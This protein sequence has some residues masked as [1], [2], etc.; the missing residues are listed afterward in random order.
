[1]ASPKV[2]FR[3]VRELPSAYDLGPLMNALLRRKDRESRIAG[4]ALKHFYD[5]QSAFYDLLFAIEVLEFLKEYGGS[6]NPHNLPAAAQGACFAHAIL[7]YVRA[8]ETGGERKGLNIY[9]QLSEK[10]KELHN[11]LDTLRNK[12]IA[13]LDRDRSF[14][15]KSF[16]D[17]KLV[18]VRQG[19]MKHRPQVADRR[20]VFQTELESDVREL[21]WA[22]LEICEKILDEKTQDA[23]KYVS[24]LSKSDPQ[25]AQLIETHPFD[26][27][28]FFEDEEVTREFLEK[29][30]FG[31]STRRTPLVFEGWPDPPWIGSIL[32][33]QPDLTPCAGTVSTASRELR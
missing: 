17:D 2:E 20:L 7:L 25:I 4:F 1:M 21:L 14:G 18:L 19:P 15:S 16:G 9:S 3:R 23:A 11:K 30:R 31:V 5:A 12:V 8:T 29:G 10:Q 28:A 33:E 26:T 6:E 13:H 32:L 27:T 22:A 24:E